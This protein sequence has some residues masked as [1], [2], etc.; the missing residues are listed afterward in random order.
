MKYFTPFVSVAFML[1]SHLA[2]VAQVPPPILL[3]PPLPLGPP[4]IAAP[5]PPLPPQP[6]YSPR[7]GSRHSDWCTDRYRSYRTYDNTFQPYEGP[8]RQ[9]YSPF[10]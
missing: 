2:A 10:S 6:D 8:R 7:Y 3:P 4:P 9:C 1:V 5:P